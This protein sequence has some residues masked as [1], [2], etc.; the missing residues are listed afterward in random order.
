MCVMAAAPALP[1]LVK[2]ELV[3]ARRITDDQPPCDEGHGTDGTER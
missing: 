3:E 2:A 1:T